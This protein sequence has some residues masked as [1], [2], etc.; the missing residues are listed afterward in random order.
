M[1]NHN[2][3]H[4]L[5]ATITPIPVTPELRAAIGLPDDVPDPFVFEAIS[6]N[7]ELDF[8]FTHMTEGT[9]KNFAADGAAG[10][11]FLDGHNNR[12]LGYGRT[13][14]GRF[15]VDPNRRPQFAHRDGRAVDL[16]IQPPDQL[17]M[18]V[19]STYVIP[20][21][22][23]GGGLTY[24]STDDFIMSA[25]AGVAS[26]ISVGFYGGD[27]T[28]DICG[29]DYR[30]YNSCPH[31]AGL[32]YP[33]SEQG[34]RQVLATVS[35]DGARLSEHSAVYDGATP[36]AMIRKAEHMARNGELSQDK[37]DIIEA[38][39]SIALP[40]RRT[41]HEVSKLPAERAHDLEMDAEPNAGGVPSDIGDERMENMQEENAATL[42][43]ELE[44]SPE[45][46]DAIAAT[47]YPGDLDAAD[48]DGVLS[49]LL[50]EVERLRPLADDGRAYRAQLVDEAIAEGIRAF[51]DDFAEET[52][53]AQLATAPLA[54]VQR[55][56]ADWLKFGDGRFAG[57]PATRDAEPQEEPVV[58]D[59]RHQDAYRA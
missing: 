25:R 48:I 1:S 19:L 45:M 12:N 37:I 54:F 2:P 23:F 39:Y 53:R 49:H 43:L 14:A 36:G 13:F 8:Y 29:G 11:Q 26:D 50:N 5:R 28:C 35:I 32:V 58:S 51:G 47:G 46:R 59:N 17:A 31:Y 9:L 16:A 42:E 22:R 24:A 56:K 4:F 38:R 18:A 20:G 30:S 57:G 15:E 7:N 40:G 10:V 52:Y 55:M 27:W 6:S 44:F 3:E 34:E 33:V 21:V 41:L